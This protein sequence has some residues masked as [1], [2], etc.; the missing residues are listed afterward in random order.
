MKLSQETKTVVTML[1][2][3]QLVSYYLRRLAAA[4]ELRAVTHDMSKWSDDEFEGFVKIN[5]IAR[6]HEY[7][8]QEYKQSL[9]EV[10]AVPLHYS[11]N[12][13]HPEYHEHG[14]N[15]M[16]LIDFIEMVI[17]WKA[18]SETY[19]RTSLEESLEIQTERFGLEKKHLYLVKAILDE[20]AYSF[21]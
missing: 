15:D 13:H 2:H 18:A 14:V 6:E 8:S 9:A 17:D 12:R 1:R 19:G 11:R 20:L 3:S 16:F 7:G 5:E 21:S 10:D 4:L